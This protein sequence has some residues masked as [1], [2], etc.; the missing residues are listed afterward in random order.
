[1]SYNCFICETPG[2]SGT[3]P[4]TIR[5][6]RDPEEFEARMGVALFGATNMD[7]AEFEAAQFNPF[8]NLFRDNFCSGKGATQEEAIEALKKD[9]RSMH[10]SLWC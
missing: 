3:T 8:H 1:M 10:E 4:V 9:M 2:L 5:H 6:Q 7:E